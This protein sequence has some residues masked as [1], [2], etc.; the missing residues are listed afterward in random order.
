MALEGKEA[1]GSMGIDTPL[2]CLS[3]S[4]RLIYDYFRQL[5][6]QVT[7]PPIDS[8]RESIIM[9]LTCYV[10]P[11]GNIL[12]RNA[13]QCER[14]RLSSPILSLSDISALKNMTSSFEGW[15]IAEIDITF[16]KYKGVDGYIAALD[17]ICSQV[18][19][20]ILAGCKVVV[21]SDRNV[22]NDRVPVSALIA[23]AGVHHY[24]VCVARSY[25]LGSK[26]VA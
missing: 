1:I 26:Q 9:S 5:F 23:C 22:D 13:D 19:E 6:A 8:I 2:A 21:L 12:E 18:S 14:L 11:Q 3:S 20:A 24:L 16:S 15:N 4:P 7:N 17:D 10:G 25:I